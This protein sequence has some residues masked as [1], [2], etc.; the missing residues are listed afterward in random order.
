MLSRALTFF[1]SIA[2]VSGSRDARADAPPDACF[3]SYERAQRAQKD[4]QLVT[5]LREVETCLHP[6]CPELLRTDCESWRR[7]L[8][9]DT[10]SIVVDVEHHPDAR[11]FVDD[12]LVSTRT[13]VVVD[14][15]VHVVRAESGLESGRT[16]VTIAKGESR[17]AILVRVAPSGSGT[18][19]TASAPTTFRPPPL[20]WIA[21][22]VAIV[23]TAS[24]ATFGLLGRSRHGDLESS[25][26]TRCTSDDAS[27]VTTL[28]V[29]ADVSLLI[30]AIATGVAVWSGVTAPSER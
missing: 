12:H 30:A 28:Y 15:G 24:F 29:A 16:T 9:N 13:P 11:V 19:A 2:I 5:A 10:P 21:T 20:F 27:S 22:G 3:A 26:G 8:Q 14:P 25:C 23:G 6:D 7:S 1:L 4:G 17:R 18:S